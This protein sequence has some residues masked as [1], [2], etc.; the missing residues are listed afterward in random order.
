MSLIK[1]Y[2]TQ[3]III[4]LLST[5]RNIYAVWKIDRRTVSKQIE[6]HFQLFAPYFH[7]TIWGASGYT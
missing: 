3:D 4:M 2:V 6:I 1:S 5:W 7:Y